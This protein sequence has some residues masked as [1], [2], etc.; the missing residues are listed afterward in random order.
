MDL[1]WGEPAR[2][3][4]PELALGSHFQFFLKSFIYLSDYAGFLVAACGILVLRAGI[5]FASHALEG[6]VSTTG[7]LGKPQ[8]Y[9]LRSLYIIN[10]NAVVCKRCL[11]SNFLP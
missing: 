4:S 8:Y 3:E 10:A 6:E 2:E 9:F 1:A 11:L 7:P 5:E